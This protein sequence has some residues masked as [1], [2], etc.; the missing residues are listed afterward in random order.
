MTPLCLFALPALC[1]AGRLATGRRIQFTLFHLW[2][3]ILGH[4]VHHVPGVWNLSLAS[5]CEDLNENLL[6]KAD[7]AIVATEVST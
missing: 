7:T 4:H 5:R 3:V 6:Q 1:G 2:A